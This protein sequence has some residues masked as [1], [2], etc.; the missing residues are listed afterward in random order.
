M[1]TDFN[2]MD[3]TTRPDLPADQQPAV[4]TPVARPVLIV[5]PELNARRDFAVLREASDTDAD[6]QSRCDL[7]ALLLDHAEKA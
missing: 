5:A 3:T 7:L 6:Y 4:E 1:T 2:D